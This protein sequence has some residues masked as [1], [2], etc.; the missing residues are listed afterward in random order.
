M[1]S[2]FGGHVVIE[3]GQPAPLG[4]GTKA[5][6]MPL[7]TTGPKSPFFLAQ[8]HNPVTSITDNSTVIAN[9]ATLPG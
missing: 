4:S 5:D 8:G 7:G 6:I 3:V 1:Q 2:Y 9:T